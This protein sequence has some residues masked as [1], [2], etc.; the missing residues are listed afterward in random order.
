MPELIV[1]GQ[2]DSAQTGQRSIGQLAGAS[3]VREGPGHEF[4]GRV[5]DGRMLDVQ[6]RRRKAAVADAV[7]A[8]AED[9]VEDGVAAA[10]DGAKEGA[11]EHAVRDGAVQD[12]AAEGGVEHFLG[13][14]EE[15]ARLEALWAA[16]PLSLA[17]VYGRR[18]VGKTTLVRHFV[19]DKQAVFFTASE[20]AAALNVENLCH[21]MTLSG[22]FADQLPKDTLASSLLT[23]SQC[24]SAKPAEPAEPAAHPA[25]TGPRTMASC[26]PEQGQ[27]SASPWQAMQAVLER[28]FA[29]ACSTP[30]V[31]VVDEYPW[32]RSLPHFAR[33]L[34]SLFASYQARFQAGCK[35][36]CEDCLQARSQAGCQAEAQASC[37]AGP[38]THGQSGS[39]QSLQTGSEVRAQ[40]T[41]RLMVILCGS[42]PGFMEEQCL[43]AK[44]PLHALQP[45][46]IRLAP[47]DF[48][49][50]RRHFSLFQA[51]DAVRLYGVIGGTVQY[52]SWLSGAK[53]FQ[54]VLHNHVLNPQ[55]R[56]FEEPGHLLRQAVRE[57]SVYNA[58][59][60]AIAAGAERLRDIARLAGLESGACALYLN[61]LIA[62]DLVRREY[63][64]GE[65]HSRRTLYAVEHPLFRF[66]YR[67]VPQ[68]LSAIMQGRLAPVLEHIA[69][70]EAAF[71]Q[72]VFAAICRQWL[73]AQRSRD[74]ALQHLVCLGRQAQ[75]PDDSCEPGCDADC[76]PGRWPESAPGCGKYF[77]RW[78]GSS[79][80]RKVVLDIAAQDRTGAFVCA[81]CIWK[82]EQVDSATVTDFLDA[83]SGLEVKQAYVFAMAGFTARCLETYQNARLPHGEYET[84]V[85]LVEAQEMLARFP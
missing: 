56:L 16:Q 53:D 23:G 17:V 22:L 57:R 1:V 40:G 10:M 61:R 19:K 29:R 15:C 82:E 47:F 75:G 26:F 69:R 62:L 84:V 60:S 32:L 34:A 12:D 85:H 79:G 7:T 25:E 39:Q 44:S 76:E 35:A 28:I 77:G 64:A 14:E 49:T 3:P 20:N 78:W 36:S 72:P 65:A 68:N 45:L 42:A 71:L 43:Q 80:R 18:R 54:D 24:E 55:S 70:D 59:L 50:L 52:L 73:E 38:R 33:E 11:M 48:F 5:V 67:Y 21:A 46:A 74:P 9:A 8:A 83:C 58:I 6:V 41:G 30:L 2:S 31:L 37:Q 51:R 66:L 4:D 27:R 81:A 13:R 63:P